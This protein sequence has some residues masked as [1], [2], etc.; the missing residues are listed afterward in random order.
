MALLCPALAVVGAH[1]MTGGAM[2]DPIVPQWDK[3][4]GGMWR[5]IELMQWRDR[6]CGW[7]GTPANHNEDAA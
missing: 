6:W 3:S 4:V 7:D 5:T 2:P 1:R